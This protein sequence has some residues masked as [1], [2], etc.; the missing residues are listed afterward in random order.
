M[1]RSGLAWILLTLLP[2]L[3]FATPAS[4]YLYLPTAGFG[5]VLAALIVA[6]NRWLVRRMPI[7]L[8]QTLTLALSLVLVARFALFTATAIHGR[9]AW[10][11]TYRTYAVNL[12]LDRIKPSM[13]SEFFLPAPDDPAFDVA[14]IQ[15]MLR[16]LLKSPGLRVV[17][18]P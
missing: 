2:F 8:G 7:R 9:L 5:W 10:L 4:R 16:W 13:T 17:I 12:Q 11:E 1:A 15:P 3:A 6:L 18:A 14:S